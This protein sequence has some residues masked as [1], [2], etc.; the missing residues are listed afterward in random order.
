VFCAQKKNVGIDA[1]IPEESLGIEDENKITG[2]R[3]SVPCPSTFKIM[4][5]LERRPSDI[6]R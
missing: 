6:V 3:L 5:H 2:E 4:P 1:Y